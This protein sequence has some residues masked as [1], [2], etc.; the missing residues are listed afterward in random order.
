L[1]VLLTAPLVRSGAFTHVSD[2]A[3]HLSVMG[4][5]PCLAFCNLTKENSFL[6]RQVA[7]IRLF[8][9]DSA[10]ELMTISRKQK[11]RLIHCHS[12]LTLNSSLEAAVK[13]SLPLVI[14]LH[15]IID[16][17]K[18]YAQ[19]LAY[20]SHI[21]ATG[22]AT[23]YSAGLNYLQKTT[24][25][26]N[27]INL[28]RF[29]PPAGEAG[30]TGELRILYFGRTKGPD[31]RGLTAL[32]GAVGI[33]RQQ[34]RKVEA[35]LVGHA[36]GVFAGNLQS[37]GWADDPLSHLQWSHV[38]FGRG[39]SLREAMACGNVGLM[40]GEG[41]GGILSAKRMKEGDHPSFSCTL[42][43]GAGKADKGVIATDLAKLDENR[44]LLQTLRTE[45]RLVAEQYF[46]VGCMVDQT[47][48][49]YRQCTGNI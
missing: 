14:T 20:A 45:S 30:L 1:H 36:A 17:P 47:V 41:Y 31:A 34:G 48:S 15:G 12:S 13:Q 32:D 39:R 28:E 33:L 6:L 44:A 38:A 29:Q 2:L 24:V 23:A 10:S 35:R 27:G 5:N 7:G 16:W 46:D 37:Y 42:K 26:P 19:P 3:H 49:I 9:F 40:L 11:V 43:H 8:F 22:P 25:I 4:M 21:I 18:L